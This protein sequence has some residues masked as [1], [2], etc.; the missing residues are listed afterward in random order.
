MEG[1][2]TADMDVGSADSVYM[3]AVLGDQPGN[4]ASVACAGTPTGRLRGHPHGLPGE[5]RWRD[6]AG[7]GLPRPGP[8]LPGP[9]SVAEADVIFNGEATCDFTG[10]SV[11]GLGD[12][13][14]WGGDPIGSGFDV[15]TSNGGAAYLVLG[16]VTPGTWSLSDAD[17]RYAPEADD[18]RGASR[19]LAT[20]TAMER[21]TSFLA[22]RTTTPPGT[23]Q[24]RSTCST[25]R[26]SD[27]AAAAAG[28]RWNAAGPAM[29]DP[30][31]RYA[32]PMSAPPVA[33]VPGPP[34]RRRLRAPRHD[35]LRRPARGDLAG[36]RHPARAHHPAGPQRLLHDDGEGM[37][38]FSTREHLDEDDNL[39][40][41]LFHELV[42]W[43]TNGTET[44][45]QR[46]WGF[47]LYDGLDPR[48][49]AALRLQA[50][51]SGRHGLREWMGPTGGYR[52]YYAQ[53]PDDPL[54]AID[55]SRWEAA[56]VALAKD[57]VS[58]AQGAPFWAPIE[59]ALTATAQLRSSLAPF[60][61]DYRSEHPEDPLPLH[62]LQRHPTD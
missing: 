54:H 36:H 53:I 38:W 43:I 39:G 9:Q 34:A 27:P 12:G 60:A 61:A 59:A 44:F 28:V 23:S 30:A 5:C 31:L 47:P 52:Q 20:W 42:H 46:D 62:W 58:R 56:V 7:R 41:M 2:I 26:A 1:L 35:P 15:G 16:P 49:H 48:E 10:E 14:R 24:G 45:H 50:W 21:P 32:R 55:D 4:F 17:A 40:Q 33:D 25:G 3:G 19:P 22:R 8:Q 37:L 11:D 51:W 13:R 57:A 29:A 6:Q 18:D